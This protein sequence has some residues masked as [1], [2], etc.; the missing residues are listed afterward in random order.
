MDTSRAARL[1]ER[2]H[3]ATLG[4][5]VGVVLLDP[6][7][8]LRSAPDWA[9]WVSGQ[10]RLDRVMRRVA[11]PLFVSTGAS[12]LAAGAVAAYRGDRR[13]AGWRALAA[14]SVGTAVAV[15][16]RVNEPVNDRLRTW[17]AGDEPAPGWR[18][19]RARWDRGHRDRQFLLVVAACA[20]ALGRRAAKRGPARAPRSL[21]RVLPSA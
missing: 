17:R 20:G 11:P 12:A 9:G 6:A 14:A 15:T 5:L 1:V 8:R 13:T 16:L 21:G 18:E 2:V 19:A 10:Q 4:C 3:A 7:R